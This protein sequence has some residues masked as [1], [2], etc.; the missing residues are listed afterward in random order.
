MPTWEHGHV[1]VPVLDTVPSFCRV[2]LGDFMSNPGR[3]VDRVVV[4]YGASVAF[5]VVGVA[6]PRQTGSPGDVGPSGTVRMR[7]GRIETPTSLAH[8]GPEPPSGP[9]ALIS[10]HA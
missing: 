7:I 3:T 1:H 9:P 10:P 5:S 8:P 4:R 2:R 6:E